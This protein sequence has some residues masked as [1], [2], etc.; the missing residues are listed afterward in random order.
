MSV[1]YAFITRWQFQCP[2]PQVWEVLHD[3]LAWPQWW[4]GVLAVQETDPGDAQGI[5]GVREYTWQSVLPY[6]LRF[7]MRLTELETHR[8]MKGL[9][10]GEL[11]GVGEWFLYEKDGVTFVTYY[12]TVYTNKP[13]M[14]RWSFLLKPVFRYNHNVVMRWGAEGLARK[15][16]CTLL[17]A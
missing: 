13:W 6:R 2:L 14:N 3:S 7:S 12:W 1:S 11:E 15:L 16:N 17:S 5:N 10:F 8:R 9:A 4:K